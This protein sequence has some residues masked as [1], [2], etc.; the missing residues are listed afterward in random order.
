VRDVVTDP[1]KT[2]LDRLYA[3]FNYPHSATDPI[4]IVRRYERPDDREVVGFFASALAFGRVAS[5]LQSI[6][7]LLAVVGDHPAEYV[8]HFDPTKAKRV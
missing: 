8:R 5:V 1:L 3:E 7:R 4:Q 2:M 6:E